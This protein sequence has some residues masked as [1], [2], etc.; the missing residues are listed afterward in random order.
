MP[1][2][3][4]VLLPTVLLGCGS[5]DPSETIDRLSHPDRRVRQGASYDLLSAGSAAVEPLVLRAASGSDSLRYIA[6]QILGRIG[7]RRAIPFL[8]QLTHSPNDYVRREAILALGRMGD[9]A[10]ITGLVAV[11][12]GDSSAAARAAA[13]E[14]MG[15]LLDTVAVAPLVT[16]LDDP[17]PVVRQNVV[18][19]LNRLWT[20][21]ASAAVARSLEDPDETVRFIAAQALGAH[22]TLQARDLLRSA[23]RDTS[24]W[25]RAEAARALGMIGDASAVKDLVELLE[26][27]DGPDHQAARQA[28]HELTGTDYA[29][30][31]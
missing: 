21:D 14:A 18:A 20:V 19:A 23:L 25:V 12:A 24:V 27:N 1:L 11:L 4:L 8:Q 17:A 26:R 10:P 30:V 28:L 13:A 2:I 9:P 7:D 16:A 29:V 31:E 22:R 6:A 15:N 3:P 5:P